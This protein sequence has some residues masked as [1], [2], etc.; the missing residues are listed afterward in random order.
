MTVALL[1]EA[2]ASVDDTEPG[3]WTVQPGR[4]G[5][6]RRYVIEPDLS[7][8]SAFLAAAAVTGGRVRLSGWPAGT[9]QP[10]R[11]LPELLEAFGCTCTVTDGG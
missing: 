7:S 11:L 1:R 4:A 2:G 10:G 9:A 3:S 5:A 8:A 6:R